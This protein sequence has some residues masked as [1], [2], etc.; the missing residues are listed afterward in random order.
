MHYQFKLYVKFYTDDGTPDQETA[1]RVSEN[2]RVDADYMGLEVENGVIKTSGFFYDADIGDSL[3]VIKKY[4]KD[5]HYEGI[6]CIRPECEEETDVYRFCSEEREDFNGYEISIYM[7][8]DDEWTNEEPIFNKILFDSD[9]HLI[10]NEDLA[11]SDET[12]TNIVPKRVL[13]YKGEVVIPEGETEIKSEAFKE[14]TSLTSVVIPKSVTKIGYEAFSGCTSLTS[15]V[16]PESVTTIG[17]WAFSGCTS[18]TSII[19]PESVTTIGYCAF[20]K[21]TSLTSVVIP[22]SVT[23]IDSNA[24]KECTSLTSVVIPEGVTKIGGMAFFKCTSL[25]SVVI[26]EGVTEIEYCAFEG[27][28]SLTSVVIPKSVTEI[29]ED[30]FDKHVEIIRK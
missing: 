26:S 16:I 19:I 27:C 29:G 20:E 3:R 11:F 17:G 6:Y 12:C 13:L 25:T 28:I 22:D 5:S 30:A 1:E 18:L 21:C 4:A 2:L 8:D 14:C 24:F 9:E 7:N 10:L 15:V 23:E